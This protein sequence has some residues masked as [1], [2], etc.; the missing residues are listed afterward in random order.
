[1]VIISCKQYIECTYIPNFVNRTLNVLHSLL[2]KQYNANLGMYIRVI[3]SCKHYIQKFKQL[4]HIIRCKQ[5]I[6][7]FVNS[8][9]LTWECTVG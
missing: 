5:Y 8:T 9:M 1:M 2:C 7:N 3:I 4:V 6:P